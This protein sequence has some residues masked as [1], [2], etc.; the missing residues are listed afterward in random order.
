MKLSDARTYVPRLLILLAILNSAY[1]HS[2]ANSLIVGGRVPENCRITV[3]QIAHEIQPA[4]STDADVAIIE[5]D[6]N[7]PEYQL[8]IDFS[9]L[10]GGYLAI[11][12]VRLD[13]LDGTLGNG[14]AASVSA[15]LEQGDTPGRFL[16]KPGRQGIATVKFRAIIRV[17]YVVPR[18]ASIP[19]PRPPQLRVSMPLT[20]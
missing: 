18:T 13:G 12:E 2:F 7:L 5:I 4:P 14:L 17:T 11:S 8:A 3:I 20:Y 19:L 16:W 10:S 6:N 1:S 9:G 15:R